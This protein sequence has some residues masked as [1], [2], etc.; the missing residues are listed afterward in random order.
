VSCSCKN[1]LNDNDIK[2]A[3]GIRAIWSEFKFPICVSG[4]VIFGMLI[5]GK[6]AK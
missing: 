5:Y 4:A 6:F 2:P 3:E 1:S